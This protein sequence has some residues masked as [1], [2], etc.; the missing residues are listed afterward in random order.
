MGR[1]DRLMV[2]T[3][4][5]L[6]DKAETRHVGAGSVN[7]RERANSKSKQEV[8]IPKQEVA[9]K[10]RCQRALKTSTSHRSHAAILAALGLK[11]LRPPAWLFHFS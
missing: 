8:D 7:R 4:Q 5:P 1:V 10:S 2:H 3:G 6:V 11:L 9:I